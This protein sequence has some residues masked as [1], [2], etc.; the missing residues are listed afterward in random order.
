MT[1]SQKRAKATVLVEWIATQ[2]RNAFPELPADAVV[3]PKAHEHGEDLNFS[4]EFTDMC[5]ISIEAKN[6]RGYAHVHSDMEQTVKNSKGR[7]PV[8]VVKS[9]YKEPL[10]IL[11]W[12]DYVKTLGT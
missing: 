7:T 12:E 5:P 8:L 3:V 2:L 1:P 4:K 10:V 6:Q 9:P 11:R